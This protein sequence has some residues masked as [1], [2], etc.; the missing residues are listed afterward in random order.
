MLLKDI[1]TAIPFAQ[2]GGDFALVKDIQSTLTQYGY[3]D[4]P[5]D[6]KFGPA[7]IW[8]LTEFAYR[9]GV[10]T[11]QGLTVELAAALLEKSDTLPQIRPSGSWFDKVISYMQ[12]KEYWICRHPEAYNIV[13]IEGANPD[14]SLNDDKPN[15]FND[16][17]IVFSV[18]TDG[19][20]VVTSWE[21][22]TEPGLF[23]TEHPMVPQGAA[24]IAFNQYKAWCVGIHHPN[25]PTAHEALVQVEPILVFRDLNKDFQRQGD[26]TEYGLFAINQHWGYNAPKDDL[27][28]TSA[29]CLVGRT[30]AGHVEF[31][32][33]VKSDPR[34]VANASYRFMTAV[35][36]GDQVLAS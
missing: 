34:Y 12:A 4:P 14:G 5:V 33:M 28:R 16:L 22:T 11:A 13:Y 17:R 36:P 24:R 3:L 15:R 2:I 6:G 35:L 27:G 29:G 9:V 18:S 1:K 8:A 20:T 31:M 30:K 19:R 25:R 7:S 32:S 26:K 23:W 10:P 21:G